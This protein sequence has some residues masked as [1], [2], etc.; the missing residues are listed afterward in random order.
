M[1]LF[2]TFM[3]KR[4]INEEIIILLLQQVTDFHLLQQQNDY[5]LNDRPFY[6]KSYSYIIGKSDKNSL[7]IELCGILGYDKVLCV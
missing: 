6:H 7:N 1:A 4:M 3:I 2:Y 5:L